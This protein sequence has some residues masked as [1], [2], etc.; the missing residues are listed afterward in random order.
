MRPLT[1]LMLLAAAPA[2]AQSPTCDGLDGP[3]KALAAELVMQQ[4]GAGCC[5]D[6]IAECLK[7]KPAC[8]QPRHVADEICAMAK[9][10]MPKAKIEEALGKRAR[11]LDPAAPKAEIA[12]DE[13]MAAGDEKARVKLVVYAC[14]RCPYCQ[15]LV[16]QLYQSV[17]EGALK[18]KVRLYF[19]PF[20]LKGHAGS[21]E[22]ALAF[23]AAARMGKFWPYFQ[24]LYSHFDEF[25][26]A[27]LPQWAQQVG[28]DRA[29]FEKL[30]AEESVRQSVVASKKEGLRNK[31]TATPTLFVE[32]RE[33]QYELEP[34]AIEH[35][36]LE[37][38]ERARNP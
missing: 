31:V 8:Q 20:P 32:G 11:S 33:Y 7:S 2:A 14:T 9:A 6:S 21:T 35:V 34:S 13:A 22:G 29:Q 28:L 18:G 30:L 17:T 15:H 4:K 26:P 10:G 3:Q 5:A 37:T 19:R 38:A 16:P 24:Q 25:S 36:L 23:A 27:V 12:L 1:V